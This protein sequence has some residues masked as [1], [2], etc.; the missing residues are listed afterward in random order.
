MPRPQ[1]LVPAETLS[2][3]LTPKQ[4]QYL[5]DLVY[6]EGYGRTPNEVAARLVQMGIE[7]LIRESVI[8]K[9][10]GR[11]PIPEGFGD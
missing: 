6:E 1:N 5:A 8:D 4:H 7:A 10:K 3:P 11:F 9:R 2:V